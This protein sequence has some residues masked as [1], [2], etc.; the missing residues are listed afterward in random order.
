MFTAE[1]PVPGA[2]VDD[3]AE[4]SISSC[5]GNR[6]AKSCVAPRGVFARIFAYA[7][8]LPE[9]PPLLRWLLFTATGSRRSAD[10]VGP[11]E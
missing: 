3:D 2:S 4:V 5:K 9:S 6:A 10:T 1:R 7:F 8:A 11:G